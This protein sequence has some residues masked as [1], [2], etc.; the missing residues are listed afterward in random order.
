MVACPKLAKGPCPRR[1]LVTPWLRSYHL[2]RG[3]STAKSPV[4][5]PPGPVPCNPGRSL[6][7]P[8]GELGGALS[9]SPT[10]TSILMQARSVSLTWASPMS[11]DSVQQED[12]W[13]MGQDLSAPYA[14]LHGLLWSFLSQPA[15]W[16]F[17]NS[18]PE[19]SELPPYVIT[20]R[21]L[22][23][24]SDWTQ[25]L[26][27][28]TEGGSF[29]PEHDHSSHTTAVACPLA[30]LSLRVQLRNSGATCSL[31]DRRLS[32][33]VPNF[34]GPFRTSVSL[35]EKC[36]SCCP[37]PVVGEVQGTDPAL[38]EAYSGNAKSLPLPLWTTQAWASVQTCVLIGA[39]SAIKLCVTGGKWP[40]PHFPLTGSNCRKVVRNKKSRAWG[41]GFRSWFLCLWA[42]WLGK[43]H[44]L[45]VPWLPL[46]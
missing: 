2:K 16:A 29:L 21:N 11:L 15:H 26:T 30:P 39:L 33:F 12:S 32:F 18:W 46:L 37:I 20:D 22:I 25:L 13:G 42:V 9:L 36:G 41:P 5:V 10:F 45:S 43:F 4:L 35:P 23:W 1:W 34:S 40:E 28:W 19:W 38:A 27:A 24:D 3:R 6:F 8:Q 14:S 7:W 44:R 17:G 31:E